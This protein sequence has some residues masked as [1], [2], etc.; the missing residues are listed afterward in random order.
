MDDF[1]LLS[2]KEV[3]KLL[4]KHVYTINRWRRDG[5]LPQPIVNTRQPEWSLHQIQSWLQV[6]ATHNKSQQTTE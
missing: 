2:T 1:K 3:A 5:V 4:G 6:V